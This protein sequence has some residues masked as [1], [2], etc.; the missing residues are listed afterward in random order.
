VRPARPGDA[1]VLAGF[2]AAMARET[3]GLALD[4]VTVRGA[5]A[6]F[7]ADPARG[8]WLVVEAGGEIEAALMLTYEWSDWR[9]GFFWWIQNVYV[10]PASRRRGHYRL[11][12]DHVRSLAARD[13]E[14][15]GLRLYVERE[16][17]PAQDTYRALGMAETDYRVY[18]QTLARPWSF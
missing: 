9:G 3:E 6:A 4:P 5:V 14:V 10:R 12:H 8:R 16:N 13:P 11:L 7:L 1:E 17:R 2:N 15:C 18:E